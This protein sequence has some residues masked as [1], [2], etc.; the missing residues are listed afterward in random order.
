MTR[1]FCEGCVWPAGTMLRVTV[2]FLWHTLDCGAWTCRVQFTAFYV[3]SAHWIL[4]I[5]TACLPL[6][7]D[8]PCSFNINQLK[9]LFKLV[10]L[11]FPRLLYSKFTSKWH[12]KP[13][14]WQLKAILLWDSKADGQIRS[15][16]RKLISGQNVWTF[17]DFCAKMSTVETSKLFQ[18]LQ[19]YS[20]QHS[21]SK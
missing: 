20:A 12:R 4:N 13:Q 15:V 14:L 17:T 9:L 3:I 6:S 16:I 18:P 11:P 21:I 2:S 19:L 5:L 1:I 7:K 8:F 10:L